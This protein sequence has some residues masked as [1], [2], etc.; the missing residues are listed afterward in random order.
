MDSIRLDS[1]QTAELREGIMVVQS[2]KVLFSYKMTTK[3]S[4]GGL[5]DVRSNELEPVMAF[6]RQLE[7]LGY[8][9]CS[10]VRLP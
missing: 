6:L 2:G 7:P 8:T 4:S 10:V 1:G 5:L 3:H 9:L